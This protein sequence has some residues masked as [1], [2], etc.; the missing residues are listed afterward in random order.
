MPTLAEHLTTNIEIRA[1]DYVYHGLR[2]DGDQRWCATNVGLYSR[3]D[4]ER[5]LRGEP[6]EPVEDEEEKA[7]GRATVSLKGE[8]PSSEEPIE[9]VETD[10]LTP[11]N[12]KKTLLELIQSTLGLVFYTNPTSRA[13]TPASRRRCPSS[14]KISS[15]ALPNT[16]SLMRG[17]ACSRATATEAPRKTVWLPQRYP[18]AVCTRAQK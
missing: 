1:Y 12:R 3:E 4:Q 16:P 5:L 8:P 9:S 14:S 6:L 18:N 13:M 2:F 17:V 11:D 15:S 7:A 10:L